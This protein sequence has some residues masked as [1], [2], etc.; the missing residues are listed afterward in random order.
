MGVLTSSYILGARVIEKHIKIG[1]T[2][3]M[4]FD[5]TAIDAKLELPL[6][7]EHMN[8]TFISLGDRKKKVYKFENH[9][10]KLKK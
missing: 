7:V 4:H 5:E 6:F 3:W 1:N 8:K 2:S 10:Y 9:K